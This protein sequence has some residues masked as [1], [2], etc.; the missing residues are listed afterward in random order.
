M[1]FAITSWPDLASYNYGVMKEDLTKLSEQIMSGQREF[2]VLLL[3]A[4]LKETL[5]GDTPAADL[6][7]AL[8]QEWVHEYSYR[9]TFENDKFILLE[10]DR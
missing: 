10:T 8:L 5:M 4:G 7:L 6:K 9:I 2:P 1:P 3:E